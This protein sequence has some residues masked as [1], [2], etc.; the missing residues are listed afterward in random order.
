MPRRTGNRGSKQGPDIWVVPRGGRFSIKE[1]GDGDYLTPPVTQ[2]MAILIARLLARAN[3]S[4]LI[5][6]GRVGT[7]RLRDSHGADSPY[8]KG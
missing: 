8:R 6:E 3:R 1:A 4:E 5:I 2:R 7:I